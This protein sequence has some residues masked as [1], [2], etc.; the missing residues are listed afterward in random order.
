[1]K[2]V[3]HKIDKG[4][5]EFCTSTDQ[6]RL[7][8]GILCLVLMALS[9]GQR[10]HVGLEALNLYLLRAAGPRSE[11]VYPPLVACPSESVYEVE[12]SLAGSGMSR[13]CSMFLDA[14]QGR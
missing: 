5:N 13:V 3:N 9:D 11:T 10:F 14:V 4:R 2:Y 6:S 7:E 1:M 12:D 8:S